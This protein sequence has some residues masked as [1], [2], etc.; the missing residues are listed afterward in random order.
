MRNITEDGVKFK[1]TKT[2]TSYFI[3][4]EIS[5]E[6]QQAIGA[7][8]IMAFDWCAPFPCDYKTAKAAMER[9]HRWL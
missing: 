7:D 3:N 1:D 4:P 5:M 9:T 2:G 6:I 8:I